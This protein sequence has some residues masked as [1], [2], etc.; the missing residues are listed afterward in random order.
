VENPLAEDQVEGEIVR[1]NAQNRTFFD[2][3]VG[4][5]I[6]FHFPSSG[7]DSLGVDV[8]AQD[9][10]PRADERSDGPQLIEIAEAD[11]E[12]ALARHYACPLK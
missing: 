9:V 4:G 8:Y 6:P 1:R 10:P 5:G 12:D 2:C 7:L 11:I 3:D